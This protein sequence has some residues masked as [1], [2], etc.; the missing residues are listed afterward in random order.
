MKQIGLGI[1]QYNQD[2]DEKYAAGANRYGRGAGWAG[3]IYPFVK[4]TGVFK[5]PD[6]STSL[7]GTDVSYALNGQFS[8]YVP[9][10]TG[11]N[12]ISLA[13]ISSPA[14]T[15]LITEVL[16]SGYYDITIMDGSNAA[17]NPADSIVA[18][19][20]GSPAGYGTGDQVD[21]TGFYTSYGSN[22]PGD[23]VKYATGYLRNSAGG[24]NGNF[25]AATGRHTDGSNFVM[26]D[27]HAKFFRPS[28]VSAGRENTVPGDCGTPAPADASGGG[29]A[30]TTTC[31]DNTI[32]A[33]FNIL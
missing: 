23:L 2:Y 7:P 15:V 28:A 5:C 16:N 31:Q 27:G 24:A 8:P 14:K 4:S 3:Q 6:D 13:Q 32:A 26:S 12:G 18:N 11:S 21:L 29:H 17:G 33:T 9:L 1:L 30:A 19:Y 25:A 22:N 20:G 10:G